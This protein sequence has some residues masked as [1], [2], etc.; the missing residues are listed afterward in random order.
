MTIDPLLARIDQI[1]TEIEVAREELQIAL[2]LA[3]L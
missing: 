3:S 1:Y 2:N